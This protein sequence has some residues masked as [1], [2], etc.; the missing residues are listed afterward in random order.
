MT[1]FLYRHL[2][3]SVFCALT[4]ITLIAYANAFP[5]GFHYD[6]F[7]G[8]V[9]NPPIHSL[10]YVP[11]YFTDTSTFS[12][13]H[14]R[15]WRPV[16]QITYALNYW[17]A[18]LNPVVFRLFN[19]LFHIGTAFLIYLVVTEIGKRSPIKLLA[20]PQGPIPWLPVIPAALFAIHTVNSEV[21]NYIWARSSL[22][23]AFFYLLAFYC[24]LRGPWSRERKTNLFWHLSGLVAFVLGVA[25]KATAITLPATLL[26]YEVLFL[27]PAY[28]GPL[29]LFYA[30]LARLKKYVPVFGIF[31][32][33]MALRAILLPN[34]FTRVVEP[35]EI[36]SIVYLLSSFR[37]WVYYLRLL[38]W[39]DP[40]MVNFH[41]FGWSRSLW[42]PGV[43]LSL[44]VII[45]ILAFAW[46]LRKTQPFIT[47]FT[48]WFF[49]ALLPESSF[50]PLSEPI[51]GY[52]P[53]LANA[54]M[55]IVRTILSLTG[56]MWIWEKTHG[57]GE[58]SVSRFW[59]A[60]G[61]GF[62]IVLMALT[63]ATIKRNLDWRDEETLWSDVLKKNPTSPPAFMNLGLHFLNQQDYKQAQL[64]FDKAIQFGPRSSYA[65]L[66]RG[67]FNAILDR[68][69]QALSDYS[70]SIKLQPRS[71]YSYFYRG[72]LYLK[73][74]EYDKALADYQF[75][76]KLRPVY[77]DAYFGIALVH[78]NRKNFDAAA[79][80]C[81]K[82]IEIDTYDP[83]GHDCLGGLMMDQK[84]T[85]E[86]IRLYQMGVAHVPT[87]SDLWYS[88]GVAYETGGKY[89]EAQNAFEKSTSL[90]R[91]ARESTPE[92]LPFAE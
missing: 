40:L 55:S 75:A 14:Q 29:R 56:G 77:T 34:T 23:A 18:G 72:E 68:N 83:R 45:T 20:H 66:L 57:G 87:D 47:F 30:E 27:N 39:P 11:S 24:F 54:G 76:V 44:G 8:I 37:A 85:A 64:L 26:L 32:A 71:A 5:N 25:T 81:G 50:I 62:G 82:I 12:T 58:K 3:L 86:A 90:M 6:D 52:R 43:L 10:R 21:V 60:Y 7:H 78:W 19:F 67:Y 89:A 9:R 80:S 74:G 41:G 69:A 15:D 70:Y 4:L 13:G 61:V 38:L 16:L 79:E 48:F 84:R 1:E 17:M 31:L 65:Y 33:Y 92:K 46:R 88:L 35:R 53:S 42:D 63:V 22:L 2:N 28:Q 49:I 51:N 59:L 36:T 73:M 91:Q